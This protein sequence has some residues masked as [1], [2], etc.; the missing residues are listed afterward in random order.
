M[1]ADK[2]VGYAAL[3]VISKE[4]KFKKPY[5]GIAFTIPVSAFLGAGNYH[6]KNNTESA[7]VSNIMYNSI[8]VIVDKGKGELVMDVATEAGARGGTIINA[9]GSGIHE[10]SKV[11]NMEIEPEKEVVMIL[12]E[13]NITESIVTAIRDEL[14]I[15]KPGNGIIFIQDVEKTYGIY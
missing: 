14:E 2:S 7:G 4:L 6:Y 15:D 1:I 10:T 3:E 13:N 5:H 12:S 8:F 9:W 11:F